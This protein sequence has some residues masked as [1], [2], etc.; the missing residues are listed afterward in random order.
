[1]TLP[2]SLFTVLKEPKMGLAGVSDAGLSLIEGNTNTNQ[3][4][5]SHQNSYRWENETVQVQGQ[6][7]ES[8]SNDQ[9]KAKKWMVG[10]RYERRLIA[11][12]LGSYAGVTLDSDRFTGFWQ[13][14]GMDAG[15]RFT[16]WKEGDTRGS[17]EAGYRYQIENRLQTNVKSS[18]ARLFFETSYFWTKNTILVFASEFLPVLNR[19]D[20]W[21]WNNEV[22][23]DVI[24]TDL[25]TLKTNYGLR[26]A[27]SPAAVNLKHLDRTLITSLSAKF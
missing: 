19:M 24:L 14:Y 3:V 22:D 10:A 16:L 12:F 20:D 26:Y 18:I 5:F 9:L 13:R 21:H 25:L 6:Y 15:I 17:L 27:N 23:L 7:M 1:M 2:G 8:N 4:S 11:H